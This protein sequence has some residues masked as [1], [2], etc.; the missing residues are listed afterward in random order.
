MT[1][2]RREPPDDAGD[3]EDRAPLITIGLPVWNGEEHVGTAIASLLAQTLADFELI[4]SDNAS[5]DR[6][7]EICRGFAEDDDRIRYVRHPENFG[8]PANWNYVASEARG[9]YFKWASANDFCH[10]RFLEACEGILRERPDVVLSYARTGIVDEQGNTT[11]EYEDEPDLAHDDRL[12]RFRRLAMQ[13][14][15]NNAQQGLIRTEA[16]QRT[17]LERNYDSGDLPLM[18]E[19][20]LA[21]RWHLIPEVLFF[22]RMAPDTHMGSLSAEARRTRYYSTSRSGSLHFLRPFLGRCGVV[23]RSDLSLPEKARLLTSM[24]TVLRW[25]RDTAYVEIKGLAHSLL[26]RGNR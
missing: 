14:W 11:G 23:L 10:P 24:A 19:L 21:G 15:L 3:S 8:G 25:N 6:T 5:T 20:A 9:V 2:P 13:G 12:E 16:L 17:R 7:A 1:L 26:T 18:G 22:R 4:L